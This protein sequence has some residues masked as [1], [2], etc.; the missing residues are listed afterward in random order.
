VGLTATGA[1][2]T[3]AAQDSRPAHRDRAGSGTLVAGVCYILTS[4]SLI[5][6]NKHALS[7]VRVCVRVAWI[8]LRVAL[9]LQG[10]MIAR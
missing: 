4:S 10:D 9:C 7:S 1:A 6:F 3:A 2:A 8:C 5:L